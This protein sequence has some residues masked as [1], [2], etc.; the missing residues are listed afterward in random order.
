MFL[1]QTLAQHWKVTS[2]RVFNLVGLVGKGGLDC[3]TWP[4]DS[5]NW[6]LL[7]VS[8]KIV[9]KNTQLKSKLLLEKISPKKTTLQRGKTSNSSSN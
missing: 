1:S 5:S 8:L 7:T 4:Y 9:I 3:V 2:N 6:L